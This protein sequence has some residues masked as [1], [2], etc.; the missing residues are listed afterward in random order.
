MQEHAPLV[1]A[2]A[3][4]A[5]ALAVTSG[6]IKNGV[7]FLSEPLI[8]VVVGFLVGPELLTLVDFAPT[9]HGLEQV[10]EVTIGLAVMAGALRVPRWFYRQRWGS[11]LVMLLGGMVLMWGAS[12]LAAGLVFSLPLLTALVIGAV[13]TPTD[14]V[15]AGS[16][17]GSRTAEN[18]VPQRLRALINSES[19]ANDGLGLPFVLLPL[20]LLTGDHASYGAFAAEVILWK[21]GGALVIGVSIGV[22]CGLLISR[23]LAE[24]WT[25]RNA[26]IGL[27]VALVF[28]LLGLGK[29]V[30]FD[31]ILAVFGAGAALNLTMKAES[32][33]SSQAFDESIKR[34][35]EQPMFFLLGTLLPVRAWVDEGWLLLLLCVVI[36][37]LRRLPAVLVLSPLLKP[38]QSW[39]DL[40]FVGWFG[41]IGVAATYYA[42]LAERHSGNEL[43]W[44]L[45]SAVVVSS[46]LIHGITATP[47][48]KAYPPQRG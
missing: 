40:V 13:V 16:I 24:S 44:V 14:P 42:L 41:P 4:L 43:F 20:A 23:V 5:A 27:S 32:E 2:V 22:A 37:L 39:R 25:S 31:G 48:A 26:I 9:H 1:V 17:L 29:L 7:D 35:F 6:K 46:T 34:L 11:F 21:V 3:L 15:L 47:G 28:L 33:A 12:A 36:L 18:R 38:V 30:S 45:G 19:A 10:A 8:A